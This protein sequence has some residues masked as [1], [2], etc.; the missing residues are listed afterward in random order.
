MYVCI[1]GFLPG[2]PVHTYSLERDPGLRG[3]NWILAM[4][5]L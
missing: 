1:T 2:F 4:F 3:Q 5:K